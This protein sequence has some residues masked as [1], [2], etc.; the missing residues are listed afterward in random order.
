[1]QF[2]KTKVNLPQ[3]YGTLLGPVY[4]IVFTCAQRILNY[5][6][7]QSFI[8]ECTWWRLFQKRTMHTKVDIY[9]LLGDDYNPIAL[10]I[11][12]RAH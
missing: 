3:G 8:Y 5:L 4:V 2:I 7:I 9:I 10:P 11:V 6:T 1:M 12:K